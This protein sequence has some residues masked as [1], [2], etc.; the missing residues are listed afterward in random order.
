MKSR[1]DSLSYRCFLGR[2]SAPFVGRQSEFRL[3][4]EWELH[5]LNLTIQLIHF[6][7]FVDRWCEV[8]C[9]QFGSTPRSKG[10]LETFFSCLPVVDYYMFNVCFR[11]TRH[12]ADDTWKIE[13]RSRQFSQ[14]C[15][16][17]YWDRRRLLLVILVGSEVQFFSVFDRS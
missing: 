3:R 11:L 10:S 15:N 13:Q 12:H 7:V 1:H 6:V 16:N 8:E 9:F 5:E 14:P 4:H 17:Y 2:F